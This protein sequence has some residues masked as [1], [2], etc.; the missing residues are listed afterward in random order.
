MID[1]YGYSRCDTCRKAQKLLDSL[2]IAY[3]FIDITEQ[4]PTRAQLKAALTSGKYKLS[5][6]CNRSGV[7][8][9]ELNMK[10]QLKTLPESEV[11]SLLAQN[12]RLCKRPFI[13]DGKS[14]IVGF[15]A[16]ALRSTWG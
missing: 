12:G 4:P 2:G 10:E 9:R 7:Q 16:D 15:D 5:E 13:T 3:R 8:Y 6:L 1:F 11:L 14:I